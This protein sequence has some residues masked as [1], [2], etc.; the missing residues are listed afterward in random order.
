[1]RLDAYVP[2]ADLAH[3]PST[4]VSVKALLGALRPNIARCSMLVVQRHELPA[5]RKQSKVGACA[6]RCLCQCQECIAAC[7]QM[8]VS[9]SVKRPAERS[10]IESKVAI[11]TS[12]GVALASR[13]N[14]CRQGSS[15]RPKCHVRPPKELL[16]PY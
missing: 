14:S 5:A 4:G 8:E 13:F 10:V 2:D 3:M 7:F 16:K 6:A 15:A 11:K 12:V 1:M 9:Q